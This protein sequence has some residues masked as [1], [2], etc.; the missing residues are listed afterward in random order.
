MSIFFK[1]TAE[2]CNPKEKS[3]RYIPARVAV[4]TPCD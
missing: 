1:R 2:F 4:L 3:P